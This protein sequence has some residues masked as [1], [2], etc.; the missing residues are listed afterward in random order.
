MRW[1]FLLLARFVLMIIGWFILPVVLLFREEATPPPRPAYAS[2]RMVDK[3]WVYIRLPG[4][5]DK[6]WGNYKYGAGGNWFTW[7]TYKGSYWGAYVWLGWRNPVNNLSGGTVL[8]EE[9]IRFIGKPKISDVGGI[10]G[11]QLAWGNGIWGLY[12]I[13]PL[14]FTDQWA[15]RCRLGWKI[16]PL[17]GNQWVRCSYIPPLP[18]KFNR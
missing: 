18:Q 15:I 11:F 8:L 7:E 4:F 2:A 10:S 3:D 6:L 9:D 16:E 13:I 12:F 14:P 5:F 17:E 1:F